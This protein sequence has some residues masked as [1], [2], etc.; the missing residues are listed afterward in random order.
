MTNNDV[1][2]ASNPATTDLSQDDST[3][4]DTKNA[5][6]LDGVY[7][8]RPSGGDTGVKINIMAFKYN[9]GNLSSLS[10]ISFINLYI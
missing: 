1:C 6:F 7:S 5:N 9:N 4:T 3:S 10:S 2:S 8:I